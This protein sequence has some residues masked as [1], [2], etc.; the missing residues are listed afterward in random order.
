MQAAEAKIT[1]WRE[2]QA[3]AENGS[4]LG[5]VA[6]SAAAAASAAVPPQLA[7]ALRA[8]AAG[9]RAP[10][11]PA[12]TLVTYNSVLAALSR[13]GQWAAALQLV[14]TAKQVRSPRAH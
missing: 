6:A 13:S 8:A 3:R 4:G 5:A 11:L 2:A 1:A 10:R 7:A 14:A 12:P 9:P